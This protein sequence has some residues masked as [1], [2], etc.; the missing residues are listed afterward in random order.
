MAVAYHIQDTETQIS[1][2]QKQGRGDLT[3][4]RKMLCTPYT[5]VV[6]LMSDLF[7]GYRRFGRKIILIPPLRHPLFPWTRC[8]D[9]QIAPFEKM[10][11]IPNTITNG[12][13]GLARI[14][15]SV[16]PTT[17][18]VGK[19]EVTAIY[20]LPTLPE[21]ANDSPGDD[22]DQQMDIASESW[23]FGSQRLTLLNEYFKWKF[24]GTPKRQKDFQVTKTLSETRVQLTRHKCLAIPVVTMGR[25]ADTINRSSIRLVNSVIPP[26]CCRFDGAAA[27]RK[28]TTGQG[29]QF[30]EI[31]YKFSLRLI[32]DYVINDEF[33]VFS[34]QKDYVGWNRIFNPEK[35][36][37]ERLVN[38]P[39]YAAGERG[40]YLYDEDIYPASTQP[41]A[42]PIKGLQYLFDPR[43]T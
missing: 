39:V 4:N 28:I 1:G 26:E 30:Y 43:A 37:W 42:K 38:A 41:N 22:A 10:G 25:L 34:N 16:N 19:A 33:G 12:I 5:G 29:L 36:Y 40:I 20:T 13:R 24:N 21:D 17:G 8:T 23:D 9:I 15:V 14:P 7:G 6:S 3:I 27:G 11:Y 2:S 32:Y 35:G 18:G 31:T